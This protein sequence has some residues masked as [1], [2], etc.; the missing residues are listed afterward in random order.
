[1][2]I[3]NPIHLQRGRSSGVELAE[4]LTV[5]SKAIQ[6]LTDDGRIPMVPNAAR[7]IPF[8]YDKVM[9]PLGQEAIRDRRNLGND[10]RA[11]KTWWISGERAIE[12]SP[13]SRGPANH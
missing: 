1:M 11:L 7:A 6:S 13:W 2:L 9:M 12:D 8:D 5:E 3:R 4:N 10:V